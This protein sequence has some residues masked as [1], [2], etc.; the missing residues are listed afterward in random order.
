MQ[1]LPVPTGNIAPEL[2]GEYGIV[3]LYSAV[4]DTVWFGTNK[5]RVYKSTNKGMNWTVA[6]TGLKYINDVVFSDGMNGYAT[7]NDTLKVTGDGGL[8]WTQVN[9]KGKFYAGDDLAYVPNSGT[10]GVLVSSGVF[11]PSPGAKFQYG[12]SFSKDGG[13]TWYDLT[14]PN[15]SLSHNGI[16]FVDS[17]N[18]FSGGFHHIA[19]DTNIVDKVIMFRWNG[20]FVI[21]SNLSYTI[22]ASNGPNGTI[23]PAGTVNA[24]YGSDQAFVITPDP[25]YLI[26]SLIVNGVKVVSTPTYT[27]TNV[28]RNHTIRATF[29]P[30]TF[31]IQASSGPNGSITPSGAVT[32]NT[33]TN[34]T[35]TITPNSGYVL[36][37]LI[38]NGIKRTNAGSYTFT[39]VRA[40]HTIR[41]VFK[42]TVGINEAKKAESIVSLYPNP[43]QNLVNLKLGDM[44]KNLNIQ[45]FDI[46]GRKVKGFSLDSNESTVTL[47]INDLQAGSYFIEISDGKSKGIS[48]FTK[49]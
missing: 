21:P 41:V 43:A 34:Q 20:G 45:I 24:A 48:K 13:V 7:Q 47:D 36:D 29:I 2:S 23:A 42:S 30:S 46:S 44:Q 26:D 35:F 22:T 27:F 1:V 33:G 39:N 18:G 15:D 17:T 14:D 31:T 8:T 37:S 25:G 49:E 19:V 4:G 9:K 10:P 12:S 11:R 3:N 6:A 38:V 28:V 5:G 32:V 40:N 16:A